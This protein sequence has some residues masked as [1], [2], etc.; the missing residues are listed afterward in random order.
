MGPYLGIRIAQMGAF[1]PHNPTGM[2]VLFYVW[3][4]LGVGLLIFLA[5]LKIQDMRTAERTGKRRSKVSWS[6]LVTGYLT[7]MM[8]CMTVL[9]LILDLALLVALTG[10]VFLLSL[11]SLIKTI[12]RSTLCESHFLKKWETQRRRGHVSY[13]IRNTILLL[14]IQ[15]LAG[16]IGSLLAH[17]PPFVMMHYT[18]AYSY[19]L[20]F[21][22]LMNISLT[23]YLWNVNNEK[24]KRLTE[25]Q[26]DD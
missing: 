19:F 15:N 18:S 2:N 4:F 5:F 13:I 3:I 6:I 16:V 8:L 23:I 9:S 21:L 10:L 17:E 7:F 22:L 26:I 25:D 24:F 1:E 11:A 20:L 12:S 14:V